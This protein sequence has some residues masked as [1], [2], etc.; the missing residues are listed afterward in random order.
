VYKAGFIASVLF[1]AFVSIT[2][3]G[4]STPWLIGVILSVL[5]GTT[6]MDLWFSAWSGWPEK[7]I[8]AGTV[9]TLVA[10]GILSEIFGTGLFIHYNFQGAMW[11]YIRSN[12]TT[13]APSL[14]TAVIYAGIDVVIVM[15]ATSILIAPLIVWKARAQ[16]TATGATKGNGAKLAVGPTPKSDPDR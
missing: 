6:L 9:A 1:A 14:W 15:I 2:G 4:S 5:I 11:S 10:S 7:G 16:G 13:T 3:I 8:A 12:E